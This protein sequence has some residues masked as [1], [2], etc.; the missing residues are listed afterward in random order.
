MTHTN[1]LTERLRPPRPR[2]HTEAYDRARTP[3]ARQAY[4]KA[5]TTRKGE[6]GR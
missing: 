1:A 2:Y 4:R 3:T 6:A 5:R